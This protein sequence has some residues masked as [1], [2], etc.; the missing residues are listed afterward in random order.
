MSRQC[1]LLEVFFKVW[2]EHILKLIL[3]DLETE[4]LLQKKRNRVLARFPCDSSTGR[5]HEAEK[6][7][8][9]NLQ[10]RKNKK[11]TEK[12]ENV[13]VS[14]PNDAVVKS[15]TQIVMR[16]CQRCLQSTA[17]N[18]KVKDAHVSFSIN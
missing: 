13:S 4:Q 11:K 14:T 7:E 16:E 8:F 12:I 17:F 10:P 1:K 3:F 5:E 15:P 6:D 18:G 9:I 2:T